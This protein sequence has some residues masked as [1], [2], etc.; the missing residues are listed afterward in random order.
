MKKTEKK[1]DPDWE[2]FERQ[3]RICKAFANPIR[4]YIL[5]LLGKQEWSVAELQKKLGISVP[6]LSQHMTILKSA[7]VIVARREGK[8]V[9]CSLP[10][11]EV[12]LACDLIHNVLKRQIKDS[13]TLVV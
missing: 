3:S 10:I 5:H 2:I 7:G 6:N 8:K 4:L 1:S 12:K 11:P 9:Y 13:Q